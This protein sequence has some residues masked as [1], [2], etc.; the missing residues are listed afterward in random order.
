MDEKRYDPTTKRSAENIWLSIFAETSEFSQ[1]PFNRIV[2]TLI[3][4]KIVKLNN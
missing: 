3:K 2:G 4:F 1:K